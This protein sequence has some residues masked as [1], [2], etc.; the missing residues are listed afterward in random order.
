MDYEKASEERCPHCDSRVDAVS[1]AGCEF[2]CGTTISKEYGTN[3]SEG[4][5]YR[6]TFNEFHEL[7]NKLIKWINDN[8]YQHAIVLIDCKSSRLMC[9]DMS[10][11]TEQQNKKGSV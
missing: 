2:D 10:F 3:R 1:L 5:K 6:E 7:S 8:H 11:E 9:S 4:C